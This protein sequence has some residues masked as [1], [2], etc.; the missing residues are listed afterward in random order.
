[1]VFLRILNTSD[2]KSHV[3]LESD[4]SHDRFSVS[5][6]FI[7]SILAPKHATKPILQVITGIEESFNIGSSLLIICL[8]QSLKQFLVRHGAAESTELLTHPPFTTLVFSNP[9][10][11]NREREK[12]R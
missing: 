1:M 10:C 11:N 6:L 9:R 12:E 7:L 4:I 3:G 5:F 8:I 2:A